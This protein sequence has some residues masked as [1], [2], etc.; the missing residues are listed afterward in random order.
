M[1]PAKP[2][3]Q[4]KQVEI[5]DK[6][7]QC[8]ET[9]AKI[10]VKMPRRTGKTYLARSISKNPA[11]LGDQW[12]KLDQVTVLVMSP[13]AER[14]LRTFHECHA[15]QLPCSA[16]AFWNLT[17]SLAVGSPD[18]EERALFDA[19]FCVL[20]HDFPTLM[21]KYL[22]RLCCL[23]GNIYTKPEDHNDA[24][25]RSIEQ[26]NIDLFRDVCLERLEKSAP[27]PKRTT[28]DHRVGLILDDCSFLDKRWRKCL[29]V[30]MRRNL[31]KSRMLALCSVADANLPSDYHVMDP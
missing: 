7:K 2:V 5:L 28:T 23:F 16:K 10:F 15:Y 18:Y 26:N 12:A 3:F 9:H 29:D 13:Y 4:P 11:L 20:E 27:P 24:L 30:W 31:P 6:A 17:S 22:G 21:F 19:M 25:T 1:Q 14:M 8:A